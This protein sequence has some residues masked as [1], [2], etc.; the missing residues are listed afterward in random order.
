[1]RLPRALVGRGRL[2]LNL[3]V[4]GKSS[5]SAPINIK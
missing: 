5:C 2:D 4:E 1:M 3:P